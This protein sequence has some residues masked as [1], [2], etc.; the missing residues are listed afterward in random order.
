MKLQVRLA[1]AKQRR[2]FRVRNKIRAAKTL[3]MCIFR[4]N[5]H[6]YAQIIDDVEGKTLV[7]ASTIDKSLAGPGKYAGNAEFA[8]K[9]GRLLA[10]RAKE[11][12]I[13]KVAFDRGAYKYHGR[14]LALAEAAREGGLEF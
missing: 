12:G 10:E 14:V 9:V 4:S 5:N 1:R 6:I 3:R 11:K 8:Q 13:T 7:S 2:V